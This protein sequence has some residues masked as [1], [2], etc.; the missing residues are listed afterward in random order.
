MGGQKWTYT[1]AF[2]AKGGGIIVVQRTVGYITPEKPYNCKNRMHFGYID[3]W[4]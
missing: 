2:K 1:T 3:H 4:T